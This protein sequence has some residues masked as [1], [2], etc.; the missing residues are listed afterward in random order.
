[1][2]VNCSLLVVLAKLIGYRAM[3]ETMAYI[4]R[5]DAAAGAGRDAATVQCSFG[6]GQAS[7]TDFHVQFIVAR[8]RPVILPFCCPVICPVVPS[9][10]RQ[11]QW[12]DR[13]SVEPAMCHSLED[14]FLLAQNC[15][16]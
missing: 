9:S 13:T 12:K 8:R 4:P 7:V 14:L 10:F 1:M 6:L 5:T 3:L 15:R 11:T 16:D 2:N